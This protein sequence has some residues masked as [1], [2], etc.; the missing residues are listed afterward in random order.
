MISY[1]MIL[2]VLWDYCR[3][4]LD[5][6]YPLRIF[7]HGTLA[8]TSIGC[9][10]ERGMGW[11]EHDRQMTFCD[12]RQKMDLIIYISFEFYSMGD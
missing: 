8:H 2:A 4:P 10:W 3:L 9:R 7:L 6:R 5:F 11:Q 12:G 1:P